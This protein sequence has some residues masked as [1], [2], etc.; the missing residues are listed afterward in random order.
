MN[1][2]YQNLSKELVRSLRGQ[3]SQV[4][5]SRRLG[6]T[7][8]AIYSWEAGRRWPSAT[9]FFFIATRTGH[10]LVD[11]LAPFFKRAPP[12]LNDE[13]GSVEWVVSLL[14]ELRGS[15]PIGVLAERAGISRFA[16]S[17]W[18]SGRA[19]PR[20]PQLLSLIEAATG[21][22][23]DF[24][25][26]FVA[27]QTLTSTRQAW[28]RLEAARELAWGSPWAQAV[29]LALE[30]EDYRAQP[31]HDNA[32]LASRLG[33]DEALVRDCVAQLHAAHRI[34]RD[35]KR[36]RP[37]EIGS[38]D[39]RRARSGSELKSHWARA[40][41]N[42]LDAADGMVSYN[43]FSVSNG[44]LAEIREL[45]RAHYRA[46]RR[47]VDSSKSADAVVLMNLQLLPLDGGEEPALRPPATIQR[48]KKTHT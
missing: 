30:L 35:G 43:L 22:L 27:P 20:L 1:V 3:R 8:N 4:Q 18:L 31:R 16:L 48:Q 44:V 29:W 38:V 9:R 37:V 42:R 21:R 25:A 17:R 47:L 12:W 28:R 34:R 13:P 46:V 23:L 41:L 19:E 2:N 10:D 39:V 24:V 5:L 26:L 15:T 14:R 33:L 36:F 32:W 45:Q 40:G 6:F 11:S 7:S